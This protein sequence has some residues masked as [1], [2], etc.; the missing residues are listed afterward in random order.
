M[1]WKWQ[2]PTHLMDM[3]P[4]DQNSI[5]L[6]ILSYEL[7]KISAT[8]TGKLDQSCIPHF[9]NAILQFK[10]CIRDG[11]CTYKGDAQLR[12]TTQNRITTPSPT[13]L[14]FIIEVSGKLL[15]ILSLMDKIINQ[16]ITRISLSHDSHMIPTHMTLTWS[17]IMWLTHDLTTHCTT[18]LIWLIWLILTHWNGMF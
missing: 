8:I 1:T 5:V 6:D 18:W 17:Q 15:I 9:P 10:T 7:S 13:I 4:R 12:S 2:N 11:S 16:E 14:Y 3:W